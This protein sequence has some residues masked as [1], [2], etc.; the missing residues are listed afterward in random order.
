MHMPDHTFEI[1]R[2]LV[3]EAREARRARR[4]LSNIF[5]T[6]NM[7]GVGALGIIAREQSQLDPTLFAWCAVALGFICLIWQTSNTYY[8]RALKTKYRIIT[9]YENK[10][11]ETPLLEEYHAMGGSKVMRA[12]TLERA[13]PYLFVLGYVVFYFVQAGYLD[14]FLP[15]AQGVIADVVGRVRPAP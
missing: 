9:A 7:A 4:E 12:F 13:M 15:W 1:Y 14:G 3:E 8:N 5:L 10:L 6:L 2:L 11:G